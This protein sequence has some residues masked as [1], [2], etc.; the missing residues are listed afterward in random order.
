MG[1]TDHLRWPLGRAAVDDIP[2]DDVVAAVSGF[3]PAPLAVR[4]I[5]L[6]RDGFRYEVVS[7]PAASVSPAF[8]TAVD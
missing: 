7:R 3:L 1:A 6:T 5:D 8:S 2:Y 4:T